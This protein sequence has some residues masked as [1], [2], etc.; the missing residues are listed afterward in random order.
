MAV[1]RTA[2]ALVLLCLCARALPAQA[3][4]SGAATLGIRPGRTIRVAVPGEGRVTGDVT[5]LSDGGVTLLTAAGPRRFAA[6]PDTLWTRERALV[7]GAVV[8]GIAG[9]G[10]GILL[11]LVANALCEYDCGSSGGYAVAGGLLGGVAGA[12]L[13]TL[14]GAGIPRWQRRQP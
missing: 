9:V 7:G 5:E 6:L 8:G 1:R 11:G 12:A 3:P 4:V 14:V 2:L 10:G 13:G